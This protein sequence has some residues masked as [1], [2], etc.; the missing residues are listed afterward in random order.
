MAFQLK[1]RIR[2][3]STITGTGAYVISSTPTGYQAFSAIDNGSQIY[4][5]AQMG[6]DW[7]VG[8]GTIIITG[9]VNISRDTILGS[10]NSGAAVSWSSGDK[11]VILTFPASALQNL[12]DGIFAGNLRVAD[13][14]TFRAGI[15]VV[16]SV[17]G[18]NTITGSL[19]PALAALAANVEILFSPAVENTG[20]VTLNL[21]GLGAKS[22]TYMDGSALLGGELRVNQYY[23]LVYLINSW[24]LLNPSPARG[25]FTGTLSG[26]VSTMQE[27][28]NWIREGNKIF[29]TP[30][31]AVTGT[32]N[33][34]SMVLSGVTS[35]LLVSQRSTPLV[36]YNSG[37][38]VLGRAR[39]TSAT[40]IAFNPL[41]YS[42]GNIYLS[43]FETS[44][45][46]G[47]QSDSVIE[48]P[49]F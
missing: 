31:A 21:N 1:D 26:F 25:S 14:A 38:P 34:A 13:T 9:S 19:D 24:L 27:T 48:F 40:T 43:S 30:A 28:F 44:G 33:D 29:F 39:R 6:A 17:A 35:G 22:V 20:A 37:Q 18:T 5:A 7:E 46:K 15:N 16:E 42:I 12:I 8:I 41:I 4:Y 2:G 10:S 45:V 11:D 47:L 32:S 49:F 23:K 36:V 3:V